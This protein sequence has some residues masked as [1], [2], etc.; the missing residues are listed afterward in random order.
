MNFVLKNF[1]NIWIDFTENLNKFDNLENL[2][3]IIKEWKVTGIVFNLEKLRMMNEV[4]DK[5]NK[6]LHFLPKSITLLSLLSYE[7]Y[8][9]YS[10][11]RN[12][13]YL[14]ISNLTRTCWNE[15]DVKDSAGVFDKDIYFCTNGGG[16]DSLKELLDPNNGEDFYITG[17]ELVY[18]RAEV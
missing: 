14:Y 10:I 6:K 2:K 7:D 4:C 13:K 8:P 5:F 12:C 15:E 1:E 11:P 16:E 18:D 9:A 3:N 17:Y